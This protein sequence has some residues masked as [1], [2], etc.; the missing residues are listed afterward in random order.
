MNYYHQVTNIDNFSGWIYLF[1][2]FY[3]LLKNMHS[4]EKINQFQFENNNKIKKS[5][6]KKLNLDFEIWL[7]Y[8][9]QI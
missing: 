9:K 3:N 4:N 5:W 8:T 1:Y 7:S 6:M 2:N